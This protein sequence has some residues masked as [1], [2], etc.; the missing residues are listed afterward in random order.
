MALMA[1]RGKLVMEVEQPPAWKV[2]FLRRLKKVR[3][4]EEMEDLAIFMENLAEEL[5]NVDKNVA[6]SRI[7]GSTATILGGAMV[8][9]GAAASIFTAGLFA[10]LAAFGVAMS[11]G[12]FLTSSG[13]ELTKHL[14]LLD[15]AREANEML[16][17]RAH[18]FGS[19][20]EILESFNTDLDSTSRMERERAKGI[21]GRIKDVIQDIS[22]LLVMIAEIE[23]ALEVVLAEAEARAATQAGKASV[24]TPATIAAVDKV[25]AKGGAVGLDPV[26]DVISASHILRNGGK[27]ATSFQSIA[28]TIRAI[29]RVL[30]EE[31][32]TE[33]NQKSLSWNPLQSP[34][35][36]QS[37][38]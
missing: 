26:R 13:S 22:T 32:G 9:G 29:M 33:M 16:R 25:L 8:L 5:K 30:K 14:I 3:W 35:R 19:I 1:A 11:A 27:S 37:P 10:P 2:H 34:R 31:L 36:I 21:A 4:Q 7:T 24:V 38:R 18:L 23:A 20:K 17:S 6:I 28:R 15:R 12:G